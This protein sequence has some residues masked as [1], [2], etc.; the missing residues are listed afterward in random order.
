M[1]EYVSRLES[2]QS[3]FQPRQIL[4]EK[5]E[6]EFPELIVTVPSNWP[7]VKLAPLYDVHYGNALHASTTFIRHLDWLEKDPYVLTWNGG[8]LVENAI[9]GSPGIFS[10]KF[11]SQEQHD[12]SVEL[13]APIQ[14]KT[15]FAIP[16]NHEARTY[17]QT[18]FDLARQFAKDLRVPYFEDYCFC[19]I[20]WRGNNFRIA[21]HHGTGA[22]QT[23][24][25]QRNAAR[26]DMP[27][28]GADMYWT[29]HLHQPIVD[30]V[31]RSDF[32]QKAGNMVTRQSFVIISPSYLQYFKGYGAAKRLS[33]GVVGLTV[34]TLNE[35]G[36]MDATLHAKGK[37][38]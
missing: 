30:L 9:L 6:S 8:D 37:R 25:A 16:G 13:V 26:K 4:I 38:L 7:Y 18:G 12:G 22:A 19:T 36:R 20:K 3:Q 15:L 23:A 35:D 33:P 31:Y 5:P 28:V 29:G 34:V 2:L 32:D 17:R 1:G 10:Q 21:A 11:F 24:G 14:H 27:W